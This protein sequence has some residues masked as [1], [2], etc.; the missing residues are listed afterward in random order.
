MDEDCLNEESNLHS[1][2][3]RGDLNRVVR[4]G[5]FFLSQLAY[6]MRYYVRKMSV[7]TREKQRQNDRETETHEERQIVKGNQ[8][9]DII[10]F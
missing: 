7:Y 1:Q 2:C 8:V 3:L 6:D 9:C 4:D 5:N 10:F